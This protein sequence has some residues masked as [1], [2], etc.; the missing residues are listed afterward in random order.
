MVVAFF[1]LAF[2]LR[3]VARAAASS[4]HGVGARLGALAGLV[5]R[6][7]YGP[8]A[9]LNL[10]LLGAV[11]A[12]AG[13][14]LCAKP[15]ARGGSAVDYV[16]ARAA[17]V[18]VAL[19]L[20][21]LLIGLAARRRFTSDIGRT[22]SVSLAVAGALVT[23]L[24]LLAKAVA[25][26]VV[27][28]WLSSSS[29]SPPPAVQGVVWY[30]S[31]IAQGL[32]CVWVGLALCLLG[33]FLVWIVA[34]LTAAAEE[35]P[36]LDAA[37]TAAILPVEMWPIMIP[38]CWVFLMERAPA[39][40]IHPEFRRV[41]KLAVPILGVVWLMAAV[42]AVSF[43]ASYFLR[44][45]V[46]W[47]ATRGRLAATGRL[48]PLPRLL[49]S[50]LLVGAVATSSLIRVAVILGIATVVLGLLVRGGKIPC[51]LPADYLH[52]DFAIT[53]TA[54]VGMA[55]LS[56]RAIAAEALSM[57]L[58]VAEF[59][60]PASRSDP[61][62]KAALMRRFTRV[63]QWLLEYERPSR[64]VFVTHSQGTVLA[65]EALASPERAGLLG[66]CK[67]ALVTMGSPF[68][69]LYQHYFPAGFPPLKDARWDLLRKTL[70]QWR[71]LYRADDY[72]GT[73]ILG[74]EG[75][76]PRN[77]PISAGGHTGYWSD[78]E[79]RRHLQEVIGIPAGFHPRL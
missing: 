55:L 27:D 40:L 11:I 60:R 63:V 74:G 47:R 12:V 50:P 21:A 4:C 72:V 59:F 6:L 28:R 61:G 39:S 13:M 3:H 71:N 19:G 58:D 31:A 35:R 30:A 26:T 54:I 56:V 29:C 52:V 70:V 64:V 34:R 44:W 9:A 53:M 67:T 69:H 7:L 8:V 66:P 57:G 79:V 49:L 15:G 65:T 43:A 45:L 22:F 24:P 41:F 62:S 20:A 25:G 77:I 5:A 36:S 38:T 33:C 76:F 37:Y 51:R 14:L 73:T 17:P 18:F 2:N 10:V 32:N 23:S 48:D 16:D 78:T 68:G 75:D 46:Q 42:L 1:R